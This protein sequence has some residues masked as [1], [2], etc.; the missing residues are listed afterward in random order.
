M[1]RDVDVVDVALSAIGPHLEE[2]AVLEVG[3]SESVCA[4]QEQVED[5]PAQTQTTGLT[6][7]TDQ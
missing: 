4:R 5:R 3:E 6:G 1:L 7:E 2:L